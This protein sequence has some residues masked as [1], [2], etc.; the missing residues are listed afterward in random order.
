MFTDTHTHPNLTSDPE[1][2]VRRAI[3]AGVDRLI[4]PGVNIESFNSMNDLFTKFPENIRLAYGIHPSEVQEE[5]EVYALRDVLRSYLKN[6]PANSLI[7]IGEIGIDLY[8]D[9]TFK[10][11]Q[12]VAFDEQLNLAEE[13]NLPVIIHCR[14]ALEETLEVLQGHKSIPAV[15]HSFGG[16]ATDVE[17]ILNAGN[18]FFGINGI[19]TFKNSNLRNVISLIPKE[20]ILLET[21]TPY[22][23]PVPYRGRQNE[24]AYIP[25][26]AKTVSEVLKTSVDE[27]AMLTRTNSE[28]LFGF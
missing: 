26:I 4:I 25:L 19:V 6:S 3:G 7:A 18:Y 15:F 27:V 1:G 9:R 12:L 20:K 13:I 23:A 14:E 16:N 10:E 5:T 22:L 17:R 28:T 8:H 24:S 11:K 2:I 21:D